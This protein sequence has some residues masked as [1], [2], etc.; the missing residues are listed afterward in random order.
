MSLHLP[1]RRTATA[2]LSNPTR[3]TFICTQCRHA[4]LLRRPK[5]PYTF[6]Q[7]I[8][9]SDGSTF[10]H[11]TTSPIAVY[12]STRDTRNAPLWNPSSEKLRNVEEDEAGRLAAF[13]SKFGRSWDATGTAAAAE[14]AAASS[15]SATSATTATTAAAEQAGVD[16]K[17][18]EDTAVEFEFEEDEEEDNL[19]D[20]ISSFGQTEG[21][22]EAQPEQGKGK[23]KKK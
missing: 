18:A 16:A 20:L 21:S 23:G 8:T 6:T 11:R 7:L 13:R 15:T 12:R 3:T 5:R 14:A 10:T 22:Q 17:Q 1:I 9:L 4:T 19:L 2:A